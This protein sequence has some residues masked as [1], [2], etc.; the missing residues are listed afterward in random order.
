MNRESRI[1]ALFDATARRA[2]GCISPPPPLTETTLPRARLA[3]LLVLSLAGTAGAQNTVT[4]DFSFTAT[5][6]K[7]ISGSFTAVPD[8]EAVGTAQKYNLRSLV[9]VRVNTDDYSDILTG[10]RYQP[11]VSADGFTW[12]TD[13]S[14]VTATETSQ[15]WI[16]FGAPFSA[17]LSLI[18]RSVGTGES[19]FV[20]LRGGQTFVF[21]GPSGVAAALS[22]TPPPSLD[23]DGNGTVGLLT[24][25]LLLVRYLI[26]T[27]G[28]ALTNLALA[29]DAHEDRDTHQEI[30]A[31]LQGLV[32]G[33][34]LDVD[35]NGT[36]G[37]LTDGLLTV[38]YLI[39]ARGSALTEGAA[40]GD[41]R[42]DRDTH[43]EIT[44]YL[45]SLMPSQ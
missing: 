18:L 9:S 5:S 22:L 12:D 43:E 41:A 45:D 14:S 42:E 13:T 44:A 36:V 23:V 27:R 28:A 10:S 33:D 15:G 37:L 30:A 34:V 2:F 38:R 6:G 4:F 8:G 26:G 16:T 21:S 3:F 1:A 24:D 11:N 20:G 31:Y 39:G 32:D 7:S 25:G 29:A 19:F 17:G 40:A 35:G